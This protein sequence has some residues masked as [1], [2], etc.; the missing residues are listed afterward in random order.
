MGAWNGTS[1]VVVGGERSSLGFGDA[2][3]FTP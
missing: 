1:F 3:S 2:A